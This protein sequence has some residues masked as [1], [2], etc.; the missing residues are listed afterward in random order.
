MTYG[1][2]TFWPAMF[3]SANDVYSTPIE[4]FAPLDREFGFTL[5]V[6]AL[7][8]NAKCDR[9]F[10][11]EVDGLAQQWAGV[12]WM[13]PPY[14]EVE[15]WMRKAYESGLQGAVVVCLVPSR[16]D[17]FWWHEYAMRSSEIRF[18][19]G[20]VKFGGESNAPFPSAIVIFGKRPK[21]LLTSMEINA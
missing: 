1:T 2:G 18:I 14:S 16:T 13:N 6:C 15:D 21:P 3:S 10:T 7:P 8:E 4:V 20:R 12:C 19:R 17:T 9:Y 5:D 11:P